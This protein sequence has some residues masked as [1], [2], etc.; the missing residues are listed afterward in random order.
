MNNLPKAVMQLCT[1]QDLN[2]RPVD[3]KSNALPVA[4]LY[5]LNLVH[6][7][8]KSNNICIVAWGPEIDVLDC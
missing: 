7:A 1:E 4:P 6:C 8:T 5:H 3:C 2:P